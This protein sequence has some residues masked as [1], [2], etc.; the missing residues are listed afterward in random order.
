[1]AFPAFVRRTGALL[2]AALGLSACGT[3]GDAVNKVKI[4]R[5]DPNG[6][7]V[8]AGDPAI[9][10]ERRYRLHGALTAE[11]VAERTGN[12]YTIFWSVADRSA[13][14]TVRFEYLQAKTGS[15]VRVIERTVD[16]P[17]A[18]NI[19]EFQVTGAAF[20]QDGKVLAWRILLQR[21]KETLAT[22]E[23]YL[24]R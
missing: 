4:L 13:P 5:L 16:Q 21:G 6:Q 10:F 22:R 18:S 19:T 3:T 14:V 23:S 8:M 20:A 17:K 9:D 7:R 2:A 1:M 15:Q 11:E 24:W 12:Y